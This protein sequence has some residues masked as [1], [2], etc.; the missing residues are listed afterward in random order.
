[1]T[2]Q[3]WGR[4]K[5]GNGNNATEVGV[6][7]NYEGFDSEW[8]KEEHLESFFRHNLQSMYERFVEE[9]NSRLDGWNEDYA[10]INPKEDCWNNEYENYIFK[11]YQQIAETLNKTEPNGILEYYPVLVDEYKEVACYEGEKAPLFGV[12][13]KYYPEKYA[14]LTFFAEGEK[15][16]AD[17]GKIPNPNGARATD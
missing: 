14:Y 1:M 12:R 17:S 3:Y 7:V 6:N 8:L 16:A 4:A 15:E 2:T 11:K 13:F 9:V 5:I 10:E